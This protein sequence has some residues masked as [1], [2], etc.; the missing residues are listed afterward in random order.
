MSSKVINSL[1]NDKVFIVMNDLLDKFVLS[2]SSVQDIYKELKYVNESIRVGIYLL[3][4]ENGF[5]YLSQ[6]IN[7]VNER[8]NIERTEEFIRAFNNGET[9]KFLATLGKVDKISLLNHL[10]INESL[11]KKD[12]LTKEELEYYR[13]ITDSIKDSQK[14]DKRNGIDTFLKYRKDKKA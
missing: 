3:S 2:D 11:D 5:I 4:L 8:I 9:N 6:R 7:N 10:G 12:G 1:F 13:V 14:D